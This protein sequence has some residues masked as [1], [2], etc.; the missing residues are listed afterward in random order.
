MK[1]L[2]LLCTLLLT[3][4]GLTMAQ[5]SVEVIGLVSDVQK[6]PMVGVSVSVKDAP[7]WGVVTDNNGRY[8]IKVDRYKTLIFSSVGYQKKEVLV[9]DN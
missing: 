8:K 2:L 6:T 1:R 5:E 4:I 3:V 9:K 7:G